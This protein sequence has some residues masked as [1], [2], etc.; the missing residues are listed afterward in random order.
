MRFYTRI[1]PN[2]GMSFGFLGWLLFW[3]FLIVGALPFIA[4]G[5]LV[6]AAVVA[7]SVIL[8]VA[9]ALNGIIFKALT[10]KDARIP[11]PGS[12]GGSELEYWMEEKGWI[13]LPMKT[14]PMT[15]TQIMSSLYGDA[16]LRKKEVLRRP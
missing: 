10:G 1:G 4:I 7:F 14:R 5:I 8:G 3:F 16:G 12:A 6:I 15:H 2:L 13:R 11:V 9:L